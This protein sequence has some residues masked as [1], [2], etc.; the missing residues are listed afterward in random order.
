M[1]C[2]NLQ[3]QRT[4]QRVSIALMNWTIE[5]SPWDSMSSQ[6]TKSSSKKPSAWSRNIWEESIRTFLTFARRTQLILSFLK[7]FWLHF[8]IRIQDSWWWQTTKRA[9]LKFRRL[10]LKRK[11]NNWLSCLSFSMKITMRSMRIWTLWEREITTLE[12]IIINRKSLII[13]HM[14]A[15]TRVSIMMA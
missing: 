8:S 5:S 15:S 9:F 12:V 10:L 3:L 4:D 14:I 11:V 13:I 1:I 2:M 7:S 6:T